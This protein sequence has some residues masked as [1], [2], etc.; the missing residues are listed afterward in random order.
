LKVDKRCVVLV[1]ERRGVVK[2]IGKVAEKA[3]GFWVGIQLDEPLGDSNG[4]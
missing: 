3:P 2:Y 1:G 4:K